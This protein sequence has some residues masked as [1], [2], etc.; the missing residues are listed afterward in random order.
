MF[1]LVDFCLGLFFFFT[2]ENKKNSAHN[3]LWVNKSLS[4]IEPLTCRDLQS[5]TTHREVMHKTITQCAESCD[6]EYHHSACT[7][8]PR[9]NQR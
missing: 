1:D 6:D 2:K 9:G 5:E 3:T 8:P 7:S 4:S